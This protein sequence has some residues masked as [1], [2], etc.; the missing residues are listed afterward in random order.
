MSITPFHRIF[1][2]A[3]AVFAL[4]V[5]SIQAHAQAVNVVEYYN[6]TLDSYFITGRSNEQAL[7]D[8]LASDFRR[9]GM[10]FTA[11]A[12][13]SA[14]AGDVRICR[15]YISVASP[16]ASTHFYGRERIDCE[17]LV[18][19]NLPGFSYE[20]FDFAVSAPL[21]AD[22]CPADALVRVYRNFRAAA[23]G[24][25]ANH[26]YSVSRNN[27][28]A[29]SATGFAPEGV[30]FCV[31]AATD[32]VASPQTSLKRVLTGASPFAAGC[33]PPQA[34]TVYAG[35]EVEPQLAMNPGNPLHL[36]G[37]WQQDRWSNGAARGTSGA[38]S[39]DGGDTWQASRAPFSQC[40]GGNAGNGGD[41]ERATDPWTTI[42]PDG[43]AYQMALGISGAS[44]T[45]TSVSAMLAARSADGGKSWSTPA[46]LIRDTG[47]TFFNDKN[48]L[49]ADPRDARFIYAV[50]GRL[51]DNGNGPAW[52]ARSVNGGNSWEPARN[53]YDPG[54]DNQTFGNQLIV[55]PD[56]SLVNVFMDII[57]T[58][59]AN[60]LKGSFMRLVRS[61]DR[62]TTWSAPITVAEYLGLGV[63]EPATGL[64][65]RDG[66]G[67]PSAA[68]GPDGRLHMVWQD[69]RFSKGAYDGIAY[70]S[71]ADGGLTW[72]SVVRVNARG[73]VPAFTPTIHVRQ[74]GTVG[75]SY[76][77]LRG[78]NATS[79]ARASTYRLAT[80]TNGVLWRDAGIEDGFDITQ[81]PF[82]NGWFLGDYQGLTG[83][84]NSFGALYARANADSNNRTDIVFARLA[85][86]S[87][88]SATAAQ[89][90]L[91]ADDGFAPT[92][93]LRQRV[94]S[95][96]ERAVNARRHRLDQ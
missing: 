5:C 34:G 45:G 36:L 56:G 87:L 65:V 64:A 2:A 75:V 8:G 54:A 59:T 73:D 55:M 82:A 57:R 30:A 58:A 74:D 19:Q 67:L 16:F 6:A 60:S 79:T 89:I 40:G 95:G 43:V 84:G 20:G 32:V 33:N 28:E 90:A 22:A 27:A 13:A 10:Q 21:G 7:L 66:A 9:T 62:G 17:S 91:P 39:F 70:S 51:R 15:F 50:W 96:V 85:E 12:A 81:A 93:E 80:S 4:T 83:S 26:R 72:S 35:G 76:F 37:A 18:T 41:Y 61:A 23:N 53:V 88:K 71:S 25:T 92:P 69:S 29:L 1:A 24:R 14:R 63:R 38:V 46:T 77:D 3:G 48:M 78:A 68:V 42:S 94:T 52:F 49:V 47:A 31:S 86:G 44:F 11:T